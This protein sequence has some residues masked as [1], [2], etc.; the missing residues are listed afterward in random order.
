MH[1]PTL[2]LTLEWL[3]VQE[4]NLH[5]L[6]NDTDFTCIVYLLQDRV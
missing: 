6:Y 4:H 5:T 1:I 2:S 3:V